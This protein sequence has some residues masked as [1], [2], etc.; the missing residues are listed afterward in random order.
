VDFRFVRP[1]LRLIDEVGAE[2][3]VCSIW[4]DLRPFRGLAGLLDWR[5]AGMLSSRAKR[6]HLIG[7]VGEVTLVPGHPKL[8]FDKVI[9]F[10]LGP[11][12]TFEEDIFRKTLAHTFQC[13][14]GLQIRR[15]VMEL[16]GRGDDT[17][18]IDQAAEV[19]INAAGDTNPLDVA[20]L[21]EGENAE[22]K[23]AQRI[24]DEDNRRRRL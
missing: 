10:G 5:L 16:P 15:A 6:G 18:D 2:A 1:N 17:F 8:S 3:I 19:I 20:W 22:E 9:V 12:S 21:I 11:Q 13:L 23:F 24:R 14:E 4:Q 7:S